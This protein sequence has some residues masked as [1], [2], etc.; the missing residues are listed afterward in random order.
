MDTVKVVCGIIYQNKKILIC[1]RR[2][3]LSFAGYW[4]FPGGKV[5]PSE[6]YEQSLARE[7]DEELGMKVKIVRHFKTTTYQ[8]E[9]FAIELISFICEFVHASFRLT[10]HDEFEW[11]DV[12]DLATR[13]LA[14]ADVPIALE[15][16]GNERQKRENIYEQTN[17][18]AR[19]TCFPF[20]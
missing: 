14:P 3:S 1:R 11:T 4:E 5:E 20:R 7:L 15:I 13:K 6:T 8:Y 9:K 2:P 10:D 12:A 16:M 17:G 19:G 18:D